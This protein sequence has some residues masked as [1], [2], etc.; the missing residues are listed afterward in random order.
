MKTEREPSGSRGVRRG[1]DPVEAPSN[2]DF[3]GKSVREVM[4]GSHSRWADQARSFRTFCYQESGGPRE[5]CSRIRG[6]CLDWLKPEKHTKAQIVDLV[7]L[8]QFLKVLPPEMEGWVR[9][10]EPESSIQAVALAERFLLDQ[11]EG[12]QVQKELPEMATKLPEMRK[13]PSNARRKIVPTKDQSTTTRG[14]AMQV[15]ESKI[16]MEVPSQ[17][18]FLC[19]GINAL[20]VKIEQNPVTAKTEPPAE[21]E[22]IPPGPGEPT[23]QMEVVE[24]SYENGGAPEPPGPN[25]DL[26]AKQEKRD[27]GCDGSCKEDKRSSGVCKETNK[28]HEKPKNPTE[29][30]Q[31]W[32]SSVTFIS[33]EGTYLPEIPSLRDDPEGNKTLISSMRNQ[34]SLSEY[35]RNF[36]EQL[37]IRNEGKIHP[38]EKKHQCADCGKT[39]KFNAKLKLHQRIHTGEKPHQC[40]ECG[41]CFSYSA[42]LRTHL[43]T[44]TGEKPYQCPECGRC[45]GH[46][47]NYKMHR[48]T[49]EVAK[50][51]GAQEAI[52]SQIGPQLTSEDSHNG[53]AV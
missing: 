6:L 20:N 30:N 35:E 40:S 13:D 18:P 3:W 38:A 4:E 12:I 19:G 2:E 53:E 50:S 17:L 39:F 42:N 26:V 46:S 51:H 34:S 9:G 24:E 33:P 49:H 21:E 23:L 16:V 52:P 22:Y 47:G 25:T 15:G 29:E 36:I 43:R 45:F 10:R 8:E 32:D 48:K 5:V 1:S 44:H 14:D 27:D 37:R 31:N 41:R 28:M 11:A 7:I